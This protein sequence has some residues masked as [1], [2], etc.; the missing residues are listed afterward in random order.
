[1]QLQKVDKG[2]PLQRVDTFQFLEV[3]LPE[4][5]SNSQ[6]VR[7]SPLQAIQRLEPLDK[8]AVNNLACEVPQTMSTAPSVAIVVTHVT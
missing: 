5:R 7:S 2:L 8:S 6:G 1:M 4:R 3:D